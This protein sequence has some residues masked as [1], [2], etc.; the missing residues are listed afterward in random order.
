MIDII[1]GNCLAFTA[2]IFHLP[3]RLGD[4]FQEIEFLM[5]S[6]KNPT[7]KSEVGFF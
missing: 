2:H 4:Y 3:E 6:A 1:K 5:N 7:S